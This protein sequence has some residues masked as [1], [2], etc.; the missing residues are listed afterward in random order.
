MLSRLMTPR[1][2]LVLAGLAVAI[3]TGS[4]ALHYYQRAPAPSPAAVTTTPPPTPVEPAGVTLPAPAPPPAAEAAD[5]V[6][7][8][9][10]AMGAVRR[11][12]LY[13]LPRDAR[14]DDL[15][16]AAGGPA[17]GADLGDI[18]VLAR[19]IDGTTLTVPALPR[20]EQGG[21]TLALRATTASASLNPS[22]YLRSR[23]GVDAAWHQRP[24]V[25][26]ADRAARAPAA[27]DLNTATAEELDA[28][29]GIGPAL[30]ARIIAHRAHRPLQSVEDLREVP[31]IGEKTVA[32][33]LEHLG[34][35]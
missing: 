33:I 28:L 29:P 21:R 25:E 31:G 23:A 18:D 24:S 27:F 9:V 12:G 20:V 11:P 5:P 8:A 7:L 19:L 34:S 1:E 3:V 17:E 32:N 13:Y 22:A 6:P 35:R 10:A 2:Q 30:A 26:G 16:Q 4:V 15:L 14:V